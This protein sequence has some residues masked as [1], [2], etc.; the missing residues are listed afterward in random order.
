MPDRKMNSCSKFAI[1][2]FTLDKGSNGSDLKF[3]KEL[4]NHSFISIQTMVVK[5]LQ[6]MCENQHFPCL[7]HKSIST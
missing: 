6:T 2:T 7:I 1:K 5:L 4:K 3:P